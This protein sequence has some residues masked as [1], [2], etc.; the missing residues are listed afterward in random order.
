MSS[1]ARFVARV[2]VFSRAKFKKKAK[3]RKIE[4]FDSFIRSG[5]KM[6]W[7]R[8]IGN[9]NVTPRVDDEEIRRKK[10][11]QVVRWA[12]ERRA[13]REAAGST[14][15]RIPSLWP[16]SSRPFS[17][18]PKKRDEEVAMAALSLGEKI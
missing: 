5:A 18:K 12:Q 2:F 14:S 7:F 13:R 3:K 16:L 9:S 4:L 1:I 15:S 6:D 11:E 8:S 17:G 10:R